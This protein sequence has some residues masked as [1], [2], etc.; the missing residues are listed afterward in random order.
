MRARTTR[1]IQPQKVESSD[2]NPDVK[3]RRAL[4]DAQVRRLTVLYEEPNN[5]D[6]TAEANPATD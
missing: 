1:T 6:A 5:D 3:R 2:D 4:M